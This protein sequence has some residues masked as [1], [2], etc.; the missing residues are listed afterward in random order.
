[1]C[2]KTK[3]GKLIFSE[4]FKGECKKLK[5]ETV[6]FR[7]SPPEVLKTCSKFTGERPC[8]SV[9]SIKLQVNIRIQSEYGK[10]R[11]RKTSV[12]GHVSRSNTYS[13]PSQRFNVFRT[14]SKIWIFLQKLLK[15]IIIFPKRSVLD[16]WLG[17]ENA[18]LSIS[19]DWPLEWPRAMYSIIHIQTPSIIANSDI[20]RHIHV[21]YLAMLR[22]ISNPR[23]I[24]NPVKAYP[25]IFTTL[26]NTRISRTLPY[27]EFWHI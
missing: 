14:L 21:S 16:L 5:K 27:S 22:H 23:H 18:Y 8:Q 6:N 20:F 4:I 2:K 7:S 26:C 1:M 10:I 11:T 3:N 17:S 15:A 25:S 12:F 19:T 9:I 24:Q 13:E